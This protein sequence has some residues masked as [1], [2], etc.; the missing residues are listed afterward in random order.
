M[1]GECITFSEGCFSDEVLKRV[2]PKAISL[3]SVYNSQ[4]G[5]FEMMTVSWLRKFLNGQKHPSH[6]FIVRIIFKGLHGKSFRKFS[7]KICNSSFWGAP[8]YVNLKPIL[9][10]SWLHSA[11]P[12]IMITIATIWSS[13]QCSA[14]EVGTIIAPVYRLITSGLVRLSTLPKI[15]ELG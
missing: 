9:Q 15:T 1:S 10:F 2:C 12:W 4:G 6:N 5:N 14:Y 8:F 13:K 7:G 3:G 11:W